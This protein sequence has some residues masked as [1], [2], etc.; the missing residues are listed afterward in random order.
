MLVEGAEV[1]TLVLST[2]VKV[3]A[4]PS[5]RNSACHG[6]AINTM[7]RCV[8]LHMRAAGCYAGPGGSRPLQRP[9]RLWCTLEPDQTL[10]LRMSDSSLQHLDAKL[11]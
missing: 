2:H 9:C 4:L 3:A 1:W 5:W 8:Q 7:L 6:A 10:T 11:H